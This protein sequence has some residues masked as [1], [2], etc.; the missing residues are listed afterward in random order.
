MVSMISAGEKIFSADQVRGLDR[1]AIDE[2]GIP[3]YTLM[4]RAGQALLEAV[5]DHFPKVRSLLVIC[6]AGNNAGDGYVMARLAR[7]S[8]YR[9]KVITLSDPVLL[10]GDAREAYDDW[11][12]DGGR[13]QGW[14]AE[15]LDQCDLV[16]DAILG[17]GLERPLE[18]CSGK[19]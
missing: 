14:S 6:G 4:C 18:G 15:A 19:W 8:G 1:R 9:V 5:V 2:F 11:Q 10:K 12:K 16:V 17:T 7:R 3:G 13:V